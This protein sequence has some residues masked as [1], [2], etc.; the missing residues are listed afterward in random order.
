M[1]KPMLKP[2]VHYATLHTFVAKGEYAVLIPVDH[3]INTLNGKK[4]C[5]EQVLD[6]IPCVNDSRPVIETAS[7]YY[8]P[9]NPL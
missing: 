3:P 1:L 6:F 7:V 5:T 2:K 4:I 8:I 9:F